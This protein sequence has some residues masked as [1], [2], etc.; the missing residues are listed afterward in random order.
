MN[1][2]YRLV[3]NHALGQV[4]VVSEL[5]ASPDTTTG[6]TRRLSAGVRLTP[7]AL[8]LLLSVSSL[9][10]MA[11]S[12]P[13]GGNIVSGS[14]QIGAPSGN[15]LIINQASDTLAINWQRFTIGAGQNVTFNQPGANSIA[16][17]RVLGVD[18]SHIM[19]Q[20]NANGRVFLVNPNGVLFGA[21]AQ[22]NVGGLVASSLGISDA[23]FAAGNYR[24]K[25]NGNNAAVI[26]H[27]ALNAT[28]GGAIALLG[29][30]VSN[31][32]VIVANQGSV[33][34]AA[35]NAMTLDFAG[36]GLL[37]VQVDEAMVDALVE[38]HQLIKAD[39][40]QVLLTAHAGDALLRTV[41]NNTG[42]IQAR[43]LGEK[44]G[45]IVLLG[46]F[47]GGT[48]QVDGTLDASAP[49]GGDGGFIDTSGAHVQVADTAKVTTAAQNGKTGTW[50]I[51]PTDFTIRAGSAARTDSGIG[52][53]TLT[54]NLAN[55]SVTLQTVAAGAENGDINVNAD[56][57]Y[58][59][60]KLTLNA[61]GN[62]NI[63]A[64][65]SV[66][67]SGTLDLNYGGT[68]GNSA[69][70]PV[71]GSTLNVGGQVNFAQTGAGLLA[72]NGHGYTVINSLAALQDIGTP[73]KLAG[74]YALGANIDASA[75][76]GWNGGEGFNPLGNI[77]NAFTGS[78]DGLG[79]TIGNLT[80]NRPSQSSIGLFGYA[81]NATLR[82]IGVLDG[83]I[84]GA[85]GVGGLVGH[86]IANNG[87]ASIANA[88]ATGQVRGGNYVGGLVGYNHASSGTA[89]ITHAYAAG[90]VRGWDYVG[91]LVGYNHASSG[92]ASIT[93]A[94]ATGPVG[95]NGYVGGLVG[96]TYASNGTASISNAYATG[97]V[98][99][100]GSAGGLVGGSS[101]SSV[102]NSFYATT[103]TDGNAI[104][105]DGIYTPLGQGKT[106]TELKQQSTFAGWGIDDK[107]GTGSIWRI[108]EGSTTPLLR[109]FLRGVT[110]DAGAINGKIYDGS[111]ALGNPGSYT[112]DMAV[113][114]NGIL[115][116]A[117]SSKNAGT[118]L[119]ADGT[120]TLSGLYSGQQGYDISYGSGSLTIIPKALMVTG[121]TVADKTYD[122]IT[123]ATVTGGTLNGLVIGETLNLSGMRGAFD[124]KNAGTGKAVTV[125]GATLTD[126][127][128][129]ASNYTVSNPT[130]VTGNITRKTLTI[131]GMTTRNRVYD[132]TTNIN[133]TGGTL[134]GLVG[135]ETL[136]LSGIRGAVADKNAGQGK[137]VTVSGTTLSDDTGLASNYTVSDPTGLTA[138]ITKATISGITG[139]SAFDKIY[140]G[141]LNV[142]L[143]PINAVINGR[144]AGDDVHLSS[145][146]GAFTDKNVGTNKTVTISKITLGG[147]D[148]GNYALVNDSA[149]AT[150][151]ITPK[152]LMITGVTAFNKV[153]DGTTN[154]NVMGGLLN[155]LVAGETLS[156]SGLR[157][158]FAD[159]NAGTNKVVTISGGTLTDGTGLAS[160]YTLSNTPTSAAANITR[161][162][163]SS[164]T[165]LVADSKVYDGGL[166]A[167]FNSATATFNGMVSGDNLAIGGATATFRDKNAGTGKAVNVSLL[168]LGGA[169]AGNYLLADSTATSTGTI[170][171]KALTI[172]G[173][174]AVNKIYDGTNRATLSGG[175]ISGL[176]GSETLGVTGL[177]AT[178][179]TKDAG[180]GKA[181]TATG[182]TLVNGGNGGLAAN[183]TISNPTGLIASILPR[184]LTVTG[185][186]A[187][188][189]AYDGTLAATLSGGSLSGL[190]S[191]ETL[192]V[193]GGTG[194]F[195]DKNAGTGKAVT[196]TGVGVADGTGL[197]SN[198]TVS[199]PTGVTGDITPK[200][201]TITGL[202]ASNK[203]YDGT[204]A[205]TLSGGSLNGLVGSE[206]IGLSGLAGTFDSANTGTDKAITVSAALDDGSH[207]GL[208]SNYSVTAPAGLTA[209]I[210]K[211]G[212]TITAG[213]GNK[214]YGQSGGLGGYS[215][216]G[217]L[218]SDTVSS[219]DL[220][221]TGTAATANVGNYTIT[222]S[223]ADGNGLSNYDI[224]YVDGV[225]SIGKA[226]LSITAG[227]GNKTYGQSGGLGGYSVG[228]LLNSDTVS[229]VDL[230]ST[231]TAATANVGNYTITASNA[232]GNGLSNYDIT[233]V[234]GVLSVGK[235]GL[236]I[237]ANAGS[238]TY[239]Q[240]GGLNG[241]NVDGL[242]NRDTVSSVDL[243]STGTAATANVGNYTITASNADGNGLSNYDIT[244]VDGVLSIG[245]AGLSIT[246]NDGSRTYG[247]T[248]GLAGYNVDGL[249]NGDTVGKV[250]LASSG[251]SATAN[252]GDYT[253]TTS[254]A[255]GAGLTNYDITYVDGVLSIGKAGLT[256]TAND[257]RSNIGQIAALNGHTAEGLVNGDTIDSV[258]LSSEGRHTG[259]RP[260]R[261]AILASDAQGARLGNYEIRYRPGTLDIVGVWP[262]QARQVAREVAANLPTPASL[263]TPARIPL[264]EPSTTPLYRMSQ[265]AI[266]PVE[267]RCTSLAGSCLR[268]PP[269]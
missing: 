173:M 98:S 113:V 83:S 144:I 227:N 262:A 126:G 254:N 244:Y 10:V 131:T 175:S 132:G 246:A 258:A 107:G 90:Q 238:K 81:E 158:T 47:D 266:R 56:V 138:D 11:Q 121:V 264:G 256:I 39:G 25:G 29:G 65:V 153:Y 133:V 28:A 120:L 51:D 257:A 100:S 44:D 267:D 82:N 59:Q 49:H 50:L 125:S 240:T 127:T 42:V 210:S 84:T 34:L 180:T 197:A 62:I 148:L 195:A 145:A 55:T 13:T 188:T 91:G 20:L 26:N 269:E 119:A 70:V 268:Q 233:Y 2:I 73:D 152:A 86:N 141:S 101:G 234:D 191:G 16:L 236:T 253:I 214:T 32:G 137:T 190:V 155:G 247:Q 105:S 21:S 89:S 151:N 149:T 263:P 259:A 94:Y 57:N 189:R 243:G 228:G 115:S 124:N 218:N 229:S 139:L 122:G 76:V 74:R 216:G 102:T 12:L 219:V 36:N 239:G 192:V 104:N 162:T 7:L 64:T 209:D 167:T 109:S 134:N 24:F 45:K 88:Y 111:L 212:L 93:H 184:T 63:N 217:L 181:V 97:A 242:L 18:G 232:D 201:L 75:T 95:G 250:D 35:G 226:G 31:Q 245:K 207:G 249:L 117:T 177:A 185:V 53:D 169:D 8:G 183:Y 164:V 220:G 159:K 211:A 15:Q 161:A 168:T 37:N 150:A 174:S 87:T 67:G 231:G 38:N 116:Y 186:T 223:N 54:N 222:A 27:G 182:S 114:L 237:T 103:D 213:N 208:A 110:V 17:N 106:L 178:F 165:S 85:D 200:V 202:S 147:S 68:I 66:N 205:A 215:V 96:Y 230:G 225:L 69:A 170:T 235:A 14:G 4:Q 130:N 3:F 248:G 160:N 198:Y 206:T 129:L 193:S 9:G 199:N 61:H 72:V 77:A 172:T 80:I 78:F 261:Y 46:S 221:S 118:Y 171:P 203:V 52:A 156:L 6:A 251:S 112:T 163:I 260:G 252:V 41:I 1:R 128:G 5:G 142:S 265:A 79:H 176:V 241:Y 146:S 166:S 135:D 71:A 187:T 157:G 255:D 40:G 140:D 58:G 43:T 136:G 143:S 194:T 108:Y 123:N 154:A 179:D 60:N 19:G 204:T 30:S 92:T 33:T 22:V 224:T 23:D 48:V 99:G 196:V